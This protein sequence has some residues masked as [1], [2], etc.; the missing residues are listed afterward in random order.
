MSTVQ[1]IAGK[2]FWKR[3]VF[4]RWRNVV[5][6]SVDVTSA[7][8]SF[9]ICGPT[10]GKARLATLD[11]LTDGTTIRLESVERRDRRPDRS[12]TRLS[13]PM[14]CGASPC[15]TLYVSTEILN[16]TCSGTDVTHRI[17]DLSDIQFQFQLL[18][19]WTATLLA[20]FIWFMNSE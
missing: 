1:D 6:D 2:W 5:N 17:T 18:V 16:W 14:Y 11:S 3:W 7:G 20:Y 15:K 13:G 19:P 4:S 10:S 8:R 9:Q 12:A